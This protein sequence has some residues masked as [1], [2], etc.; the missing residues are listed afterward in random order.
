MGIKRGGGDVQP[1]CVL[2]PSV[3]SATDVNVGRHGAP[4]VSVIV[5]VA[6]AVSI[7]DSVVIVSSVVMMVVVGSW[8][9]SSSVVVVTSVSVGLGIAVVVGGPGFTPVPVSLAFLSLQKINRLE[10]FISLTANTLA[11]IP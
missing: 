1:V 8:E 9:V 11:F 7:A 2:E 10:A 3:V 5:A 6:V 4:P